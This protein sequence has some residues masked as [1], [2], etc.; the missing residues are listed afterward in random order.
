MRY[1]YLIV[2]LIF[3]FS[4]ESHTPPPTT[5]TNEAPVVYGDDDRMD[6]YEHPSASWRA[7]ARNSVVAFVNDWD[8]DRSDPNQIRLTGETLGAARDLCEGERFADQPTPA[9]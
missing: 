7:V 9:F 6:V 5:G 4:C 3:V 8:V 1:T 2:T